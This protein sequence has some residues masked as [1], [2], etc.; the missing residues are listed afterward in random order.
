MKSLC[1]KRC[2]SCSRTI[3]GFPLKRLNSG[4]RHSPTEKAS[5]NEDPVFHL[6]NT[7]NNLYYTQ[8]T[9]RGTVGKRPQRIWAIQELPHMYTTFPPSHMISRSIFRRKK[10]CVSGILGTLSYTSAKWPFRVLLISVCQPTLKLC[11]LCRY[12][13][14][15]LQLHGDRGLDSQTIGLSN[16]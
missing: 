1:R 11:L 10:F 5:C 9:V 8:A 6:S 3:V 12:P 15:P 2:M 7:I 16:G 13:L 14:G 4:I